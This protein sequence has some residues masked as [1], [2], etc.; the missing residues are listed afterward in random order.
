MKVLVIGSG[1]R[2]HAL[3][4]KIAQSPLVKELYA[5][6]GNGG[7]AELAKIVD[8]N[9]EDVDALAEFAEDKDIDLTVVGPEAP[10]A[11]GI[12][13][14]FENRRLR[15]FGP[16]KSGARLESSKS[17]TKQLLKKL[18]VPTA[19]FAIF[20]DASAARAYVKQAG[21]PVVVKAD[22]LCGGKGV[23]V[24]TSQSEALGAIDLMMEDKIFKRA[25]ERIVIE[26]FLPGE[27][28][29]VFVL[30]DGKHAI[31]LAPAQDYKRL[32]DGDKG[33][34]T[35]GMG[36][37]SPAP[38]VSEEMM[39]RIMNSIILPVVQGLAKEG[40]KYRGVLYAGLMLTSD[41]PYVLE[42]NAR[43]G[44]PELQA[45]LPRLRGDLV[46]LMEAAI[47]GKLDRVQLAWDARSAACIVLA[48]GGYPGEY[49]IG[50]PIRG[51]DAVK[52]Q[53]DVLVFHAGTKREG[54]QM[55]TWGGRVL[56]VIALDDGIDGAVKKAYR[57]V[58]QIQF[59]GMQCRRDIAWRALKPGD[60]KRGAT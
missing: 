45:V 1:G 55:L 38:V 18:N 43:F 35:G 60:I 47:D 49:Q 22:G 2:E 54:S 44:D 48:S 32:Q 29:S 59:E 11:K 23:I 40:V 58:D 6:P 53:A 24:A 42:F 30:T 37:Y 10:L 8:L 27:E 13:D 51:L 7:I 20:D 39:T 12:V 34:N 16:T 52:R 50:K 14:E 5:A 19:N 33:P 17:F 26:E 31:P 46:E 57:A 9:A 28:A 56:N 41:G 4:W 25:G 36:A 3:V 21:L 15:I